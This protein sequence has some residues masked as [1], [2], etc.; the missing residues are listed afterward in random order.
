MD[1]NAP[2]MQAA[3]GIVFRRSEPGDF[4]DWHNA[5]RRQYVITLAGHV[6]IGLSDG[7]VWRLGPDDAMPAGDLTSKGHTTR[8]IG[9]EPRISVAIPPA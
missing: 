4:T 9:N 2:S 5:P 6:E 1:R 3:T 7:T 8:T